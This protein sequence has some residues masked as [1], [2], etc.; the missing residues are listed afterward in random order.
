MARNNE[1][2]ILMDRKSWELDYKED[3]DRR[4]DRDVKRECDRRIRKYKQ[5]I[6]T[7]IATAMVILALPLGMAAHFFLS[8]GY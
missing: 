6:I 3:L 4:Y 7:D 1:V 5:A 8:T 2:V